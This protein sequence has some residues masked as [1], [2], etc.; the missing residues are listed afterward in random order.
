MKGEVLRPERAFAKNEEEFI[1]GKS[2]RVLAALRLAAEIHKRDKRKTTGEPY[3]NH[4]IAVASI[5]DS[6]GCDEDEVVAGLL[7]DTW[8]DHPDLISLEDIKNA[9]GQR[10]AFLVD[11]VTKMKSREGE[12]NE[13]ETLRKVTRES[14]IDPGVAK[15]KLSDR[16]HNMLT[17]N[18]MRVDTQRKKAWET[19]SVY[20]PLAESFGMWEVKN[21]LQ[22]LSFPYFDVA[23]YDQV[24]QMMDGDI[25]LSGE[26]IETVENTITE[27]LD[28]YGIVAEVSHRVGGYYEIAE[29]QKKRGMRGGSSVSGIKEIPDV[30][31]FRVVLP[32]IDLEKCYMAMGVMRMNLQ[33]A[34]M[35]SRHVDELFEKAVNGYSALKDVYVFEEGAIEICFTTQ[36]REHFNKWG[37]EDGVGRKLVFTPKEELLFL[38]P[39]ATAIDIAYKL[40]PN[41]GMKAV[42]VRI[43]GKMC[44]LDVVVPNTSIVEVIVDPES[45]MPQKSWLKFAN[46]ETRRVIEK[47][48]MVTERDKKVA[49]GKDLLKNEVLMERGLLELRDLDDAAVSYLLSQLG[50][51]H[52]MSDLYYKVADGMDAGRVKK[53]LDTLGIRVGVYTTVQIEGDNAPG[54]AK[55]VA[56]ILAKNKADTRNAVER[57]FENDRFLIRILMKVDYKGKKKIEEELKRKYSEC[58][59]V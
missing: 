8:E 22:D 23:R 44:D 35:I 59:V 52:G 50:C 9:F 36:E 2:E 49:T 5:L 46:L 48:L 58:V 51:W 20:A 54:V 38:E 3:I 31:S 4:C 56:Q 16:V 37:F 40:N 27:Q 34:L 39:K 13:F 10:V 24:R 11:G 1:A 6:W 30:I 45:N 42:A 26:F 43:D 25:R 47:Q 55:D 57:V 7:H 14:L 33:N 17:M 21:L 41:L 15:I 19:L 32:D 53:V 28:R 29:K 12:K 18:G